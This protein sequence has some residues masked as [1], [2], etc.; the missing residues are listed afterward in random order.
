MDSLEDIFKRQQTLKSIE[1][2]EESLIANRNIVR[3]SFR[4]LTYV[5]FLPRVL[6]SLNKNIFLSFVILILTIFLFSFA[7]YMLPCYEG[8]FYFL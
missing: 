1:K 5:K 3:K 4:S 7:L 2:D 6:R 8:I